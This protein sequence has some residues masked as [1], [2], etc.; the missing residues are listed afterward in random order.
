VRVEGSGDSIVSSIFLIVLSE[1]FSE[2]GFIIIL[3]LIEG[4]SL[5]YFNSNVGRIVVIFLVFL[6][7]N[8]FILLKNECI[9]KIYFNRV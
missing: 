9:Y 1:I 7:K 8:Y 2:E 5:L 6:K 4:V 3:L